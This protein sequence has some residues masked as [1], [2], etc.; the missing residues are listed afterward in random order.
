MNKQEFNEKLAPIKV[1]F[2]S[3]YK[4]SFSFRNDDG[5]LVSAGGIAD[6][7]YRS[8]I[9]ANKEYS[10]REVADE[11]GGSFCVYLNGERLYEESW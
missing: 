9:T 10:I 2:S 3:Y 7:I 6:E 4:Y 5:Y 11:L 8:N 1:R